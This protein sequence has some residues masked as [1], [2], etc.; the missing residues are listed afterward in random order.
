[1]DIQS[2]IRV[3]TYKFY[4]ITLSLFRIKQNNYIHAFYKIKKNR[5]F[6]ENFK[7]EY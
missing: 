7:I 6:F 5:T 4:Y 2:K 1:M 3:N